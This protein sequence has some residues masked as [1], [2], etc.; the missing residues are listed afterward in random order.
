MLFESRF[1]V[2]EMGGD[3]GVDIYIHT[4]YQIPTYIWFFP[5]RGGGW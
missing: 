1:A 5:G 3:V 4:I 2:V